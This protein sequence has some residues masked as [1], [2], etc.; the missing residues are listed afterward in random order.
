[1]T[2]NEVEI[3]VANHFGYRQNVIVPNV[4]WGIYG[5]KYEADIV[6]LRQS[7]FAIEVEIKVTK[8]DIG[9]DLKK[10]HWHDSNYF[11]QLYF[12]LPLELADDPRINERAGV[13]AV[14]Q[15]KP[16][17]G[18]PYKIIKLHRPAKINKNAIKWDV[19]RR[20]KL[21]ELG[22]M[23]IW[24]LKSHLLGNQNERRKT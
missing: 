8:A 15:Y 16:E 24:S 12:A 7:G 20:T 22:C 6:V 18:F 13:L 4:W 23:R 21:T 10:R 9:A 11:R 19:E 14:S 2:S 3:L 17:Y 1:M 5:L